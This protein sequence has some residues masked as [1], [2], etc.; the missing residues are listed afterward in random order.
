MR[1]D[2]TA[3]PAP[4]ELATVKVQRWRALADRIANDVL[5]GAALPQGLGSEQHPP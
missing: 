3:E 2:A 1:G 4:A 5:A